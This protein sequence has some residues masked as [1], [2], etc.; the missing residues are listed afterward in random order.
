MKI[1]NYK[2]DEVLDMELRTFN[3]LVK[4]MEVNEARERLINMEISAYPHLKKES[5]DKLHKKVYKLAIPSEL[6]ANKAVKVED[7]NNIYGMGTVED[8]LKRNK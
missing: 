7:L 2:Y 5:Q 4:C 3:H 1:F 8:V 6:R